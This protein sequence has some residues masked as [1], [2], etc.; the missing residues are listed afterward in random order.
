MYRKSEKN[1]HIKTKELKTKPKTEL[2]SQ[3]MITI[4]K[5][6]NKHSQQR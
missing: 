6:A 3:T 5:K 2:Q 1:I 4:I